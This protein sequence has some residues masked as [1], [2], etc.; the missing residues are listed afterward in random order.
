[1]KAMFGMVSLLIALAIVGFLAARQLKT[2]APSATSGATTAAAATAGVALP[3]VAASGTVREQSQQIQQ[4]VKDDVTKA[5]QQGVEA[6][7][8]SPEQ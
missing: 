4:K 7:K 2:A 8:E 3:G 5:L 1:M 6:R